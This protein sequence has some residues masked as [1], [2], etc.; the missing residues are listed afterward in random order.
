MQE[1]VEAPKELPAGEAEG[2][3]GGGGGGRRGKEVGEEP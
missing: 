1:P 2:G 3:G